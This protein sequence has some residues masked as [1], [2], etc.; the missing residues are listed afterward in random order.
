MTNM[1]PAKRVNEFTK[2]GV[3]YD[4]G[5]VTRLN[6]LKGKSFYTTFCWTINAVEP[7]ELNSGQYNDEDPLVLIN[8]ARAMAGRMKIGYLVLTA[9]NFR[10]QAIKGI[11]VR[12][13]RKSKDKEIVA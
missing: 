9:E 12:P 10:G 4:D 5:Y 6:T 2:R 7:L 13:S 8:V 1:T 3:F 11:K